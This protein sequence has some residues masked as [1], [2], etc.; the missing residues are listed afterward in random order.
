MVMRLGAAAVGIFC[1]FRYIDRLQKEKALAAGMD[2]VPKAIVTETAATEPMIATARANARAQQG[3][4]LAQPVPHR[5]RLS[6]HTCGGQALGVAAASWGLPLRLWGGAWRGQASCVALW[7]GAWQWRHFSSLCCLSFHWCSCEHGCTG[8]NQCYF[9]AI[10]ADAA[11]L[12]QQP[13]LIIGDWNLEPIDS[14]EIMDG[15]LV[16]VAVAAAGVHDRG[17][18]FLCFRLKAQG[19]MLA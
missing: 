11:L 1:P 15:S 17:L 19:L 18:H 5:T 3:C 4:L 13:F 12:G 7:F 2:E 9:E 14:V 8:Q 10:L 16:D 6:K